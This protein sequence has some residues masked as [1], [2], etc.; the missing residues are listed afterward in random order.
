MIG[1]FK[2]NKP[3]ES[4]CENLPIELLN[5]LKYCREMGFDEEPKY[6]SLVNLLKSCMKR[7]GID[8]KKQSFCWEY[9]KEEFEELI[10]M[11]RE[12]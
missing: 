3:I 2:Q 6:E 1:Q 7:H 11:D 8:P 4:L 12:M 5:Y 10:K 9:P